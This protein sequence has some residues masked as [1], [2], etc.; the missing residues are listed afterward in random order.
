VIDRLRAFLNRPLRDSDR[1]RLFALAVGL[2]VAVAAAFAL[3]DDAGSAPERPRPAATPTATTVP[4]PVAEAEEPPPPSRTDVRQAKRVARRFLAGYLP[5]A[6]GRGSAQDIEGASAELRDRLID[7]RLR[8]PAAQR[9]RRPRVVLLQTE[10][11]G[12]TAL[13][14]DG[15]HRYTIPLEVVGGRVV[16]VAG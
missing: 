12:V 15:A 7:E 5:Y 8:V 2:I 16:D 11:T 4:E 14:D 10:G 6:Y 1:P 3:L 9:R 13:V